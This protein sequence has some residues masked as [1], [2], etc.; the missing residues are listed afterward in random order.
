MALPTLMSKLAQQLATANKCF[1]D[2]LEEY[3]HSNSAQ[4]RTDYLSYINEYR[5]TLVFYAAYKAEIDGYFPHDMCATTYED[6]EKDFTNR[7]PRRRQLIWRAYLSSQRLKDYAK[8]TNDDHSSLEKLLNSKLLGVSQFHRLHKVFTYMV[9]AY[10]HEELTADEIVTLESLLYGGLSTH[11]NIEKFMRDTMYRLIRKTFAVG[12]AWLI[13]MYSYLLDTFREAVTKLLLSLSKYSYLK[14]HVA[15]LA[16]VELDYHRRVRNM[17]R[18]A[19]R[20]VRDT[21]FAY[22]TYVHYD[23]TAWLK[24]LSFRIP[25]EIKHS[26][27]LQKVPGV[28]I[29][30]GSR[31]QT[32]DRASS[33]YQEATIGEIFAKIPAPR[34]LD[35]I[36]G[37]E[38]YLTNQRDEKIQSHHPSTRRTVDEL[39]TATC[40]RLVYD[41]TAH[42]NAHVIIGI[43][44]FNHIEPYSSNSIMSFLN[45]LSEAK[46]AR[47]ANLASETII[48]NLEHYK[49]QIGDLTAAKILL[50]G[51]TQQFRSSPTNTDTEHDQL[52][53]YSETSRKRVMI[54]LDRKCKLMNPEWTRSMLHT[55]QDA[56]E[57]ENDLQIDDKDANEFQSLID[58]Q[59]PIISDDYLKDLYR[60]H[61]NEDLEASLLEGESLDQDELEPRAIAHLRSFD[62]HSATYET[63]YD[64]D[65]AL[66]K[67]SICNNL[68]Q[69]QRNVD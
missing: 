51:V 40:A 63:F 7:W 11:V 41:I 15:F 22:S 60:C 42:F 45:S 55:Q 4:I 54:M 16:I 64:T 48:R 13:Q 57:D 6:I 61:D 38:S 58:C 19:I 29:K 5:R 27:Y 2:T 20:A 34:L 36:I 49:Q 59:D 33:E 31:S 43:N 39:Y 44:Q 50:N 47:M 35:F 21:R 12:I 62:T 67:S 24:K 8:K 66:G 37:S 32:P 30:D 53:E 56:H 46:I 23:L 14:K 65:G 1:D 26:L 69:Q 28:Y 25:V 68:Q 52:K 9:L 17:I 10:K 3:K 18:T